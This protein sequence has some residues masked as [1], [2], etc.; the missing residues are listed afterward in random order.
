MHGKPRGTHSD[1]VLTSRTSFALR[2]REFPNKQNI[3]ELEEKGVCY[4][5]NGKL[6]F[7]ILHVYR[8][9]FSYFTFC[10]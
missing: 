2:V 1:P 9:T 8:Y 7:E 3:M 4:N 6:T 5:I 10:I